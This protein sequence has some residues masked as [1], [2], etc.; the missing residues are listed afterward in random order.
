LHVVAADGEAATAEIRELLTFEGR[1][2]ERIEKIVPSLE[3]VFVSLIE[4]KDRAEQPQAEV[5]R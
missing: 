5:K 3:D 2:I 4:A 1:R